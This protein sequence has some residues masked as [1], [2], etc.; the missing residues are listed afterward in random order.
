WEVYPI[1]WIW[2]FDHHSHHQV[3]LFPHPHIYCCILGQTNSRQNLGRISVLQRLGRA[4][5]RCDLHLDKPVVVRPG[6]RL[7]HGRSHGRHLRD[8]L[9]LFRCGDLQRRLGPGQPLRGRAAG[10]EPHLPR[11]QRRR[12]RHHHR[13]RVQRRDPGVL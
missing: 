2:S 13:R 11:L 6:G 1:R 8:R 9:R 3:Q 4:R 5:L 12:H 10:G 7:E